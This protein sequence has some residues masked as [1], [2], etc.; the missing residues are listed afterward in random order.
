MFKWPELIWSF[1]H[2][3]DA[4][5]SIVCP[6]EPWRRVRTLLLHRAKG[7]YSVQMYRKW[8]EPRLD[9]R[10]ERFKSNAI[11]RLPGRLAN[12]LAIMYFVIRGRRNG[13]LLEFVDLENSPSYYL[14]YRNRGASANSAR[15]V[16]SLSP[17]VA[18]TDYTHKQP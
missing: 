14:G 11:A 17:G 13:Q 16:M 7:A 10:W 18:S 12:W 1:S 8:L 4:A 3:Q 6:K 2:C 15:T 5:K 9:S